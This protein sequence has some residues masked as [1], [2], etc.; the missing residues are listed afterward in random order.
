MTTDHH[1]WLLIWPG[2]QALDLTG[3]HEVFAAA[4]RVADGLGRGGLRYRLRVVATEAQVVRSESG[5]GVAAEAVGDV[6]A[7]PT[8]VRPNTLVLPGGDGVHDA[9]ADPEVVAVTRALAADADRVATVC[10]GAFLGAA[11]GL[12]DG[13][14][15]A[16]HWARAAR[17]AEQHAAVDVDPHSLHHHDG[18]VW[19]SAGVTAGIDLAL[20]VVEHDHDA[21]VAQTV[22]RWL[23][24]H[25]RRPGGQ[26]QFASPVWTPPAAAAPVRRA[27]EFVNGAPGDDHSVGNLA[28]RVGVSPRHLTRLFLAETGETPGRFV[29]RIRI[30]AARALLE[31]EEAGLDVIA[32]RCGFGSSETLRRAFQRRLGLSPNDYRHR[33]RLT[34][35]R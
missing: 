26:S 28:A 31:T 15:V 24:V 35:R 19:S 6:T 12:L 1:V 27:Q 13:R 23:V 11:A 8:A 29:E 17:L 22:G 33:F 10:T 9:A 30:D 14:R 2:V 32:E 5:L 18:P 4:N 21:E 16:T 34:A 3:P 20:A 7:D 25:L